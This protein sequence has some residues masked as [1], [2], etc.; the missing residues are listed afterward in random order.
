MG[1]NMLVVLDVTLLTLAALRVTRLVTTDNIPGQWWLYAPLYKRLYGHH[2]DHPL[3]RWSKYLD[4]LTCPFCVGLWI[5]GV[6]TVSLLLVGGPGHAADWW[7][8]LAA[9]FALNYV[10]GHVANRLD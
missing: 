6:G 7:R 3:P 9:P 1:G 4:G 8:W 2:R 10:V 5:C